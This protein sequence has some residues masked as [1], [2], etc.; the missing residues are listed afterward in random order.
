MEKRIRDLYNDDILQ[1]ALQCFGVSLQE[2]LDGFE[3]YIYAVR[4]GEQEHVLRIG[5]DL[6]R[7][8]RMAAAEIEWIGYLH[9]HRVGVPGVDPCVEHIPAADGSQFHAVLMEKVGGRPPRRE[10]WQ[11]GLLG[12]V[13][14][15]L[16]R[17]NRLARDFVPADAA[18]RRPHWY[19]E[20]EGFA[21]KFLPPSEGKVIA[22]YNALLEHFHG[23][24]TPPEA[25]GIVHQDVHGGNFFVDDAGQITLFD[26]DD[27]HYSW[28]AQDVAMAFFYVL[29]H[30]CRSEKERA[31]A[32]DALDQLLAGYR[33]EYTI[34]PRWLE[35]IP[36]F[37]KQR[38]I[39]LYIAIHRSMDLN[40]LDPWCA[41]FMKERKEKIENDVPYVEL[42]S[43]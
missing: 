42:N 5:H 3:N 13:G 25:Y 14:A 26:F 35:E 8:G 28:F 34:E 41:S 11:N 7:D 17:M 1:Q 2:E 9:A 15:L 23:L 6:H 43:A 27:C 31:F 33:E 4:R 36:N 39:D 29:P 30:D 21:E 19:T 40:D 20:A 24:P 32:R 18:V 10:D 37:L 22:K 12:R 16:G 38:E